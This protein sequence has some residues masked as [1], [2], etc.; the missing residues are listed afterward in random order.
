MAGIMIHA[1]SEGIPV[2]YFGIGMFLVFMALFEIGAG[3]A[4]G[5][6][7][8]LDRGKNPHTFW[9]A[10]AIHFLAG[11]GSIGYFLYIVYGNTN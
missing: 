6:R 2:R 8:V 11:A 9:L 5:N 3:K 10:V 7:V 4:L 1:G